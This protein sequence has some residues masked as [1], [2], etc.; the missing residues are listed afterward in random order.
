MIGGVTRDLTGGTMADTAN[1]ASNVRPILDGDGA[2]MGGPM[3][4]GPAMG[5]GPAMAAPSMA[6]AARNGALGI[7]GIGEDLAFPTSAEV[8]PFERAYERYRVSVAQ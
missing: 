6:P 4:G 1:R 2:V 7:T 3:M 8:K 5:G